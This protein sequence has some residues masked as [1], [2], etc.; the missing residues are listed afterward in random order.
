MAGKPAEEVPLT[1]WGRR[2]EC[3]ALD[4]LLAEVRAGLRLTD[5]M[6][7]WGRIE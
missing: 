3:E 7:Q 6:E 5:A 2:Q 1:L 4:G